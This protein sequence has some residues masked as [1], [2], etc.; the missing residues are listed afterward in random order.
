M[1]NMLGNMLGN[2]GSMG[3]FGSI[4]D[5]GSMGDFSVK[6]V[7]NEAKNNLTEG[8]TNPF[9]GRGSLNSTITVGDTEVNPGMLAAG[10]FGSSAVSGGE[11]KTTYFRPSTSIGESHTTYQK[12]LNKDALKPLSGGNYKSKRKSK[13]RKRSKK[14]IK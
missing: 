11:L 10:V 13:K 3:N 5:F 9:Q 14:Y 12:P 6:N 4:G 2:S 1:G 7:M 8:I